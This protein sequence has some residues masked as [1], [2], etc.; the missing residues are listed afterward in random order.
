MD[1]YK[2]SKCGEVK[3]VTEFGVDRSKKS[4]HKSQC[5]TCAKNA[6]GRKEYLQQYREEHRDYYREKHAEYR[7]RNREKIRTCRREQYDPEKAHTYYEE[8]R[9]R[10]LA[11]C[12]EY[13]KTK[14]GQAVRQYHKVKRRARIKKGDRSISLPALFDRDGGRCRLCGAMCDYNDFTV[15]DGV[16]IVGDN[17]PSI[18]HIKPLSRG[19]SHTWRNVQLAHKR[20]NCMKSNKLR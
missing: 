18:D 12:H 8:N 16:T 13:Q 17:Y 2:C 4:G 20:C 10:I 19:G 9:D 3:P 1:V 14:A 6:P 5:K 7:A 11:R 15:V